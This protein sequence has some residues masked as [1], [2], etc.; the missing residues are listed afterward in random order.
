MHVGDGST[1]CQGRP[2]AW[3][4]PYHFPN[5][6]RPQSCLDYREYF[7]ARADLPEF[8][9]H[10]EGKQLICDC[11]GDQYWHGHEILCAFGSIFS[12]DDN[13]EEVKFDAFC[14]DCVLERFDEDDE[15]NDAAESAPAPRFIPSLEQ[16]NETVRSG[17]A[18]LRDERP[19]WLDS[20]IRIIWIIRSASVQ[21]F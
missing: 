7:S 19:M 10:L 9:S 20:W 12:D 14:A 16:V 4:N 6:N 18:R 2:S 1:D 15:F 8:L 17:A 21:V 11:P 13:A 5:W 3:A